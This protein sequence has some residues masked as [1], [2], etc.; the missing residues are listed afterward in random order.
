MTSEAKAADKCHQTTSASVH[1]LAR[2]RHRPRCRV[3]IYR[4]LLTCAI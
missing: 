2:A 4:Q 3:A 1:R